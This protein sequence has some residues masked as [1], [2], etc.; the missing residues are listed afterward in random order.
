MSIN[1]NAHYKWESILSR[2]FSGMNK[3]KKL[4]ILAD[5][6]Q[7]GKEEKEEAEVEV[8]LFQQKLMD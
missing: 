4:N 2:L 1:N 6:K 8:D 3:C 7:A 5:E